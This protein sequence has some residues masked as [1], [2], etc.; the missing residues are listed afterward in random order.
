MQPRCSEKAIRITYSKCVFVALSIE[1]T[2]RMRHVVCGLP[3]S[4]IFFPTLPLKRQLLNLKCV[5]I[6][7][8]TFV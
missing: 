4:V 8:L 3:G 7:P 6:F 1:D 5:V 2:R